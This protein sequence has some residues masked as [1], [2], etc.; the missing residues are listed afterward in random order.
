MKKKLI[1][2]FLCSTIITGA[3][4][5]GCGSKAP[6]ETPSDAGQEQ[7]QTSSVKEEE[8]SAEEQPLDTLDIF[9]NFSWYPV[10]SFTG[11]IPDLIKEK[12]GVDLNVT[13]ATSGDQLGV[14]IGSGEIPDLVFTDV[15][16]DRLS[17]PNICISYPEL[18]EKYG[19]DFSGARKVAVDIAKSLSSDDTYYTLLNSFNTNEEWADLQMGAP[20]QPCLY[21]RKD[22]LDKMGVSQIN[23]LDDFMDVL[24]QCKTAYPD[25]VPY[26]LGGNSKFNAIANFM[27]VGVD[28]Y[29]PETGDYYYDAS[30]PSYKSYLQ[31]ANQMVRNGYVTAEAYANENEADGH[32][33]AYN[34]GCIFYTWHLSYNNLVQLQTESKKVNPEAEWALLP[35]IGDRG[36]IGTS[37][38][39][40]GA[41]VS[42]ECSNPEAAARILTYLHSEEGHRA[43]MWGREGIDYTLEENG[44]PVFSEEF[45]TARQDGTLNEKYNTLFYFGSPSI[46]QIYMNY[47]GLDDEILDAFSTYGKNYKD[48]PELGVSR[49]LSSTDEGI[50]FAKMEE[51][52]KSYEAKIIFAA[53]NEEFESAYQEYMEALEATGLNEY[54]EYM[55]SAIQENKKKLGIE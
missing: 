27:G 18:E 3:L 8:A 1:L 19:A 47:S 52:K 51:L 15:E 28:Q 7:S 17:N 55:R 6:K 11:I 48:Y 2:L 13:I 12:T 42:N 49:P 23:T 24:E 22:L 41:F 53:S 4:L 44:V 38:G 14:M 25:M 26:G 37:R 31:T 16:L 46:I 29:N 43:A 54:N 9:V 21:Y 40:A 34:N 50:I 35:K 45:K 32:Q 36:G 10:D 20:G 30:S 39:W 5:S 33:N